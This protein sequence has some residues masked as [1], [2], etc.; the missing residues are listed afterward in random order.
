MKPIRKAVKCL[1]IENG[2]VVITK[3]LRWKKDWIL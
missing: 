3:Y 2:K 1:L